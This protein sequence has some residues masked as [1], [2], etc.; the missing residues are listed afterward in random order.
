MR[1]DVKLPIIAAEEDTGPFV[2]ALVDEPAGKNVIGYRA[3]LTSSELVQTFTNAT[4]LKAEYNPL[5]REQ[6]LQYIP[7]D[8]KPT[9]GDNYDYWNDNGYEGR[10]DPTVVHPRDVR[11]FQHVRQF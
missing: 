11:C 9:L 10:E 4:G 6:A 2:K 8:M 1:P 3:W 7:D 5:S